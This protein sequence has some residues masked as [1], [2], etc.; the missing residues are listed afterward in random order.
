MEKI[1]KKYIIELTEFAKQKNDI[2][3]LWNISENTAE[4]LYLLVLMKNP[5]QILEIGTSNGY[6]TFWLS[7]AAEKCN[8]RVTSIEIDES[9][10]NLAKENLKNRHN[11]ELINQKA[12]NAIPNLTDKFDFVFIDAGK[13]NYIDYIKLLKSK[14]N[15]RA[16]I[17]ADNITSHSHTVEEYLNYVKSSVNYS[18]ITLPIDAGLE[19]TIYNKTGDNDA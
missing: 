13:I 19:I 11:I 10:F 18:S 16:V 8:S 6:S 17:I 7:L 3:R 9:R 2:N 5:K 4:L 1:K 15:D 14:L 12:E